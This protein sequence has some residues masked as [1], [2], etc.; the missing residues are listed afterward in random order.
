MKTFR[1]QVNVQHFIITIVFRKYITKFNLL[2]LI[3]KH[4]LQGIKCTV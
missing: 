4:Q 1:L 2:I 3:V